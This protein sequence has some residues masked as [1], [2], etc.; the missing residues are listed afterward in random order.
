MSGIVAV[1]PTTLWDMESS[2]EGMAGFGG[3]L[4]VIV[5]DEQTRFDSQNVFALQ[6]EMK[7]LGVDYEVFCQ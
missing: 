6:Y 4:S 2:V 3:R 5:G 7:T 1:H